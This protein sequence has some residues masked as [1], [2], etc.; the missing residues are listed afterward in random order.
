MKQLAIDNQSRLIKHLRARLGERRRENATLATKKEEIRTQL[1]NAIYQGELIRGDNMDLRDDIEHGLY[2]EKKMQ[3]DIDRCRKE[4]E[5]EKQQ[6][7]RSKK[8]LENLIEVISSIAKVNQHLAQQ[9]EVLK[10]KIK[11]NKK[12][13]ELRHQLTIDML[14]KAEADVQGWKTQVAQL[15]AENAQLTHMVELLQEGELLR[16][17]E[18]EEPIEIE[19][20][21]AAIGD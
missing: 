5:E 18:E 4:L 20:P 8:R 15:N 21:I 17:P 9:D 3:E 12:D 16:E 7:S 10:N 1:N 19:E 14:D 13:Y 11:Q 6:N 2:R